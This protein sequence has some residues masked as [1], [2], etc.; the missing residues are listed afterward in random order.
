[1]FL[2]WRHR[3]CLKA[4]PLVQRHLTAEPSNRML[5]SLSHSFSVTN[6]NG[7]FTQ[8]SQ[9][10]LLDGHLWQQIVHRFVRGFVWKIARVD[11]P[12]IRQLVKVDQIVYG[13]VGEIVP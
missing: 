3:R 7:L 4:D 10:K 1:M 13:F 8:F 6:Y 9:K 11:G 2:P 12:L 5:M